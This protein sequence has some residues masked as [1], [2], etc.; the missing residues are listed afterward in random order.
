MDRRHPSTQELSPTNAQPWNS[1]TH[2]LS[3]VLVASQQA[4]SASLGFEMQMSLEIVTSS[5]T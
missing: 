3:V 1:Q 4:T 5:V 2:L